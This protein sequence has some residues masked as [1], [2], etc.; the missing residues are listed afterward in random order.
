MEPGTPEKRL[1]PYA[2]SRTGIADFADR[3]TPGLKKGNPGR[4]G[5]KRRMKGEG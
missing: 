3:T 2:P 1:F 4:N 5:I